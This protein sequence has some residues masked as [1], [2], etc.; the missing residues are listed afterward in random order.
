MHW[1]KHRSVKKWSLKKAFLSWWILQFLEKP[2]KMWEN[3]DMYQPK[4]EGIIWCQKQ[5][6]IQQI[7]FSENLLAIEMKGNE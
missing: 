5:A 1:C 2:W 4:K 3:T 7:F 6:I